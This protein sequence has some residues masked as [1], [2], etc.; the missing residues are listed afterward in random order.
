MSEVNRNRI[1][2]WYFYH[3]QAPPLPIIIPTTW[4]P[5]TKHLH[6]ISSI[7]IQIWKKRLNVRCF[8]YL[9]PLFVG[10]CINTWDFSKHELGACSNKLNEHRRYVHPSLQGFPTYF[11][12]S[13][14]RD[15]N[16]WGKWSLLL[17]SWC[18]P[19]VRYQSLKF[20]CKCY[21]TPFFS[22]LI[23]LWRC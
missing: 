13:L 7:F 3:T 14:G 12:N 21:I 8:N 9:V 10:N 16:K 4:L 23:T 18:A 17:I 5:L 2:S 15:K 1:F 6:K 11:R 20:D 19:K 22:C